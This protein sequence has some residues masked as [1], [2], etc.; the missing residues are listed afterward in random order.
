MDSMPRPRPPHLQREVTRHGRAVW[1]VR[2]GKGPRIRIRAEYGTP[3]FDAEY[4]AAVTGNARPRKNAPATGTLAWLV[5]RY[6]ETSDWT[7]L[8]TRTRKQK[9]SLLRQI[10]ETAGEKSFARID[11]AAINAGLERRAK[12]PFQ[13]YHF[14]DTMRG[15]FRWAKKAGLVKINPTEDVDAPRRS[16]GPGFP[17]WSEDD[18]AAYQRRWL[19]GT[20]E[21]VW[22]DVLLYTGLRCGDAVRLGRQHVRDGVAQLE[23]EKTGVAVTLPILPVLAET[24]AAGPCGD[25]HFI[26]GKGGRPMSSD[27][28]SNEFAKAARAAGVRGSAHGV[29]KIAAT[30]AANAGATVPQLEAIFGWTGGH[31]AS[32]YTRSADRQRLAREAMSKLDKNTALRQNNM[33]TSIPAPKG[34][35]RALGPKIE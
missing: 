10:I 17:V 32:L 3:E 26:V 22:L 9:E 13:A 23:T 31:M 29:R 4:Q 12:T 15:L 27:Y 21:R 28:F 35:V 16:S 5:A 6:R 30:R 25:L 20:R 1:Y 2:V 14:L 8:S 7:V 11:A 19:V 34:K 24:L 33:A 18:V